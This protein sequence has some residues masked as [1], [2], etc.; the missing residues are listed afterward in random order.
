[1]AR[2]RVKAFT[3]SQNYRVE[4]GSEWP[5]DRP[6][7]R[8]DCYP[9]R[10]LGGFHS[11]PCPFVACAWHL[12]L[13]THPNTGSIRFNFPDLDVWEM[14]ETCALDVA[15]EGAATLD[16]VG[17]LLNITKEGARRVEEIALGHALPLCRAVGLAG[18]RESGR[19]E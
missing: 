6:Q 16:K 10:R 9:D 11:R 1:M 18:E 15:D 2:P 17:E 13:D 8:E 5:Y 7:T 14:E 3:K 12:Y 4:G 19:D